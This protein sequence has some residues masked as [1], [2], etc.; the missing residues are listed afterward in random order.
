M[1]LSDIPEIINHNQKLYYLTELEGEPWIKRKFYAMLSFFS[2]LYA[3]INNFKTFTRASSGTYTTMLALVP[4][5][6]V[7]GSLILTFNKAA[8]VTSLIAKINEFVI[9]FAGDTI[10][11]F[12]SESLSRTLDLG[13]GPV[14]LISLLITSV[15]L[16]VYIEDCFNDI[17]HVLKP[18]AYFLRLLIF[19]A[20]VTLGPILISFML[21]QEARF[22]PDDIVIVSAYV[23]KILREVLLLFAFFAIIFK[24][25]PN[26]R[27]D[28]VH[29]VIPAFLVS[30]CLEALKFV[31]SFYINVAFRA[32]S[33][34][35][36][37]YG[38]IGIIP[39][40]LLW[41]Y[42]TWI[43][44]LIGVQISYCMQ[45]KRLLLLRHFYNTEGADSWVFFGEFAPLEILAALVRHLD[46]GTE[47]PTA[48]E[49]SSECVYPV[50]AVEAILKR[51]A[52]LGIVNIIPANASK[53]Y[54]LAKPLDT[55]QIKDIMDA[56]DESSPRIQK[57]DKLKAL[58]MQL[59][60]AHND[61]WKNCD[62]NVFRESSPLKSGDKTNDE[63]TSQNES[64]G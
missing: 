9:P 44:I 52:Q 63:N 2:I 29:A 11:E 27:V 19:Y 41:L 12:L 33:N 15:M 8:S 47:T 35:T 20:V 54:A 42:I 39:F 21:Y 28:F 45:N 17:W 51:F 38:A 48:E 5:L 62:A 50:Q 40:T 30:I 43:I 59:Q 23:W 56:F 31:F 46:M 53:T 60:S 4:F 16:F 61:I 57:Y 26:T 14:G 37:L 55:I 32:D 24:I 58:V 49:L 25:L 36:I 18:R 3:E 22:I 6:I 1:K 10:A 34:Y 7:G 64:N 13:L